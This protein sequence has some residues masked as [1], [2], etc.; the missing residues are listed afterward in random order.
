MCSVGSQIHKSPVMLLFYSISKSYSFIWIFWL[1]VLPLQG[2]QNFTFDTPG[3]ID[4]CENNVCKS[5]SVNK[6]A[7]LLS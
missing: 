1:A 5:V 7:M 2:F 3:K 4:V 6:Q